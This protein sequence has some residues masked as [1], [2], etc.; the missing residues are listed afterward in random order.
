MEDRI[1][2]N[3]VNGEWMGGRVLGWEKK[4]CVKVL[5]WSEYKVYKEIK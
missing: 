2:I 3:M 1:G 5:C 4:V